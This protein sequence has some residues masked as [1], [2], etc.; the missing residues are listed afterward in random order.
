MD[1]FEPWLALGISRGNGLVIFLRQNCWRSKCCVSCSPCTTSLIFPTRNTRLSMPWYYCIV[2]CFRWIEAFEYE[3]CAQVDYK[4]FF[5]VGFSSKSEP[6]N[7][8]AWISICRK[9]VASEVS[10]ICAQRRTS[11]TESTTTYV[12]YV[13]LFPGIFFG[14]RNFI[15]QNGIYELN[16]TPHVAFITGKKFWSFIVSTCLV[17]LK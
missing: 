17:S 4:Y 16:I 10:V 2:L 12:A 13:N 3:T 15:P 14:N 7:S 11:F 1:W 6:N 8:H 9:G 5:Q